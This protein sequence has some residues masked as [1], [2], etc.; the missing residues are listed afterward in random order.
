MFLEL[1]NS[2]QAVASFGRT[3][4]F[5]YLTLIG[6]IGLVHIEPGST[7]MRGAT[8]P[9]TGAKLLFGGDKNAPFTIAQLETLVEDLEEALSVGPYGMQ[10]MEDALCNWQKSPNKFIPFRG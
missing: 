3:A 4:R 5:D 1:Y 2:M 10:I 6:K 8:G 7:F 9:R